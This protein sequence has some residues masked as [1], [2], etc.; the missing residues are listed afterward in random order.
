MSHGFLNIK[1]AI[2]EADYGTWIL[3][4]SISIMAILSVS[5]IYAACEFIYPGLMVSIS[6]LDIVFALI[7]QV[8]QFHEIPNY[9]AVLGAILVVGSISVKVFEP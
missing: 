7:I 5:A 3:W 4:I 9:M 1:G 8:V 6:S 2:Q